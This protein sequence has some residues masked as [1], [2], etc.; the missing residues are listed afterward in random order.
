[1]SLNHVKAI[2]VRIFR[3]FK[4]DSR[5]LG[6]MIL[7]PVL[8]MTVFGVALGGDVTHIDVA[9]VNNDQG[10]KIGSDGQSIRLSQKFI[11]NLDNETLDI[12]FLEN[13]QK[14]VQKVRDG[15]VWAVIRFPSNFTTAMMGEK[16]GTITV[17]ADKSNVQI[18]SA[19]RESLNAAAEKTMK[20][21]GYQ[22]P[23]H[24]KV[25][26]IYGEGAT[27]SDFL[28]PGV[29]AFAVFLLT[30]ILTLLTFTTEKVSG[31]LE[32]LLT[33]PATEFETV[34][35]Y[36]FAFG[37]VGVMQAVILVSYGVAVF[38]IILKGSLMLAFLTVALLAMASQAL[39]ILLSSA[40][41]TQAQ[42]IQMFPFIVLPTFLLSGIFW[43]LQAVPSI[44]RP[45]SNLLP[46]TYAGK[47]LRSIMVRGWGIAE[48]WPQLSWLV[49]F[50]AVF[51]ALATFSLKRRR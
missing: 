3:G 11:S 50:F 26:A 37:L 19:V 36:S 22:R 13:M 28:I 18:Y 45:F 30:T 41:E 24:L 2:V 29:I 20:E 44:I 17:K 40:A 8:A 14:A 16:S 49:V 5:S 10:G 38:D 32:R 9:I 35:G 43:P 42:S 39:G 47:A 48:V 31:T 46:P 1:M 25:S 34:L 23:Y 15:E 7:A 12:Q 4:H 51:V 33:T 27:F 6:L 21:Y